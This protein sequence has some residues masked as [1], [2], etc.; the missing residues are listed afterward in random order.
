MGQA[1]HWF[2]AVKWHV[3]NSDTIEFHQVKMK[4][5]LRWWVYMKS[6]REMGVAVVPFTPGNEVG[7]VF[8]SKEL[9]TEEVL[10]KKFENSTKAIQGSI[11]A[12]DGFK[13][14]AIGGVRAFGVRHISRTKNIIYECW[15]IPSQGIVITIPKLPMNWYSSVWDFISNIEFAP[16]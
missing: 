14:G 5:P 1:V 2:S 10:Q 8:L 3:L 13:T 12:F 9:I 7:M 4:L 15:T 6:E 16:K 11:L